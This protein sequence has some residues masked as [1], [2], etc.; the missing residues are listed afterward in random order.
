MTSTQ[1]VRNSPV[2][3]STITSCLRI[4][5]LYT[6][7]I[8]HLSGDR[9]TARCPRHASVTCPLRPHYSQDLALYGL[10]FKYLHE[11]QRASTKIF[12]NATNSGGR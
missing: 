6:W 9:G 8:P 7:L 5:L 12:A 2:F 3:R 10:R 1:C 4:S 11:L